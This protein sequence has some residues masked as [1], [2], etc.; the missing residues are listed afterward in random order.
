MRFQYSLYYKQININRILWTNIQWKFFQSGG[1]LINH[2]N[3]VFGRKAIFSIYR[4]NVYTLDAHYSLYIIVTTRR[5]YARHMNFRKPWWMVHPTLKIKTLLCRWREFPAVSSQ[6]V[7]CIR[8]R[9][10]TLNSWM[11]F[12]L[13][14][15]KCNNMILY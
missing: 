15:V 3:K 6:M 7:C 10:M 1:V 14:F 8:L 9:V 2:V 4:P 11:N 12:F 13:I 5:L